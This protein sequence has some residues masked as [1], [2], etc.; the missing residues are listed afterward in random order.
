MGVSGITGSQTGELAIARIVEESLNPQRKLIAEL[1]HSDALTSGDIGRALRQVTEVASRALR[2]DRASV[3][4]IC[5]DGQRRRIECTDLYEAETRNHSSGTVIEEE[6]APRYF[7]ALAAERTIAAHDAREDPRTSEFYESYLHPFGITAMLDSPVFVRGK[8]VAVVC[9]E[10]VGGSRRWHFWEELIAGTC[11]DFVALVLEAEGWMEAERALRSERDALEQKVAERT[12]ALRQSEEGLRALLDVTP[13]ALVLTSQDHRVIFAN[14][15]AF[16]LFEVPADAPLGFDARE[17]W[18][19][20]AERERILSEAA[21]GPIDGIETEL[22]TKSGRRFWGRLSAQR[23]HWAGEPALL[24]C[25]DDITPQK[26]AEA[27]LRDLATRDVL[28]GI[29]NRRSLIEIGIQELDRARRYGRPLT[30][31]MIDVDHFK[32]V[33]DAH[34]HAIGDEVLR[35][36]V[37][38]TTD[39]LRGSDAMG[40][41]GGEEFVVILPETDLRAAQRVLERIRSTIA[42]RPREAGDLK[43]HVTISIGIAEWTG[44]E[45]LPALVERADRACYAAK[46][47]G[48]DRVEL[49]LPA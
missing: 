20:Q 42:Q 46:H 32:R 39:L 40:R 29:H 9:H 2:V 5:G 25:V 10:H 23:L 22:R 6:R 47:A 4:R 30:A 38:A 49:A 1:M 13:I 28:T 26:R 11:S 14:P 7:Q 41:W 8:M 48:R 18:V 12:A 37:R 16:A 3:W 34:G 45:S 24:S 31:A 19:N 36:I 33:N 27:Q 21:K 44:I 43:L 15:R 35:S 17:Y